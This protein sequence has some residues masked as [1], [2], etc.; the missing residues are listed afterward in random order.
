M[1]KSVTDILKEA[2]LLEMRGKEFYKNVAEKSDNPSTKEFFE[3]MSQEENEHIKF[4]KT[5]YD[6][7]TKN[8][9]FNAPI[10]PAEDDET[11]VQILTDKIKKEI[12]AASFEAAAINSAMDFET[13]A[14]KIYSERAK[15]ATDPNEQE[16]YEMLAKWEVGHQKF[17]H[18]I[19]E[20]LKESIWNDHN[21]W[22]F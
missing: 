4:L 1:A 5:Q 21:F 2:I 11:V 17:L 8:K 22:A 20:E 9:K 16:T 15:E 19:N 18:E 10:A 7:F 13:K 12:S 3:M 6:Y 14:V